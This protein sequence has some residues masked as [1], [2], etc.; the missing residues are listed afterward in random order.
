VLAA[1]TAYA[2]AGA[3][4]ARVTLSDAQQVIAALQFPPNRLHVVGGVLGGEF[5]AGKP[6]VLSAEVDR[7]AYIAVL[8]VMRS[9][10]TTEVF[11]SRMRPEGLV[12]AGTPLHITVPAPTTANAADRSST[13][14]YEFI[15]ATKGTSWLFHPQPAAGNDF[16]S[17]GPTTRAL[18]RDIKLALRGGP[19]NAAA[20]AF[21]TA[22]IE[23]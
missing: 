22:R 20:T 19:G 10:D 1:A 14:L 11:P 21:V 5:G 4:L 23:P 3:A 17:L 13:V 18:A 9:G 2:I 7:P 6:I 8:Q 12:A 15:A 16:V